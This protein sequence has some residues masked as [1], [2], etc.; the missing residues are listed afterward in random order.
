MTPAMAETTLGILKELRERAGNLRLVVVDS[1]SLRQHAFVQDSG[2]ENSVLVTPE[3]HDVLALF[4]TAQAG[5]YIVAGAAGRRSVSKPPA[6]CLKRVNVTDRLGFAPTA[7]G[8]RT[9]AQQVCFG[10]A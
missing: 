10:E 9:Y 5:T 2:N 7:K 8:I 4:H 6:A 3:K 1:G